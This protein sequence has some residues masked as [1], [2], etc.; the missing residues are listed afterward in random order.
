[1]NDSDAAGVEDGVDETGVSNILNVDAVVAGV[2]CGEGSPNIDITLE[3]D[4][5]EL[6][7][8]SS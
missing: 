3:L 1:M 5:D 8:E 4:D 7:E 2:V 6:Y